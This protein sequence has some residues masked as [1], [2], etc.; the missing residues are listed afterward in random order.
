ME[1]SDACYTGDFRP[2]RETVADM[3]S[4]S[5]VFLAKTGLASQE[6]I[7]GFCIV[8][9]ISQPYIWSIA[10]DPK[11]QGRG[12]GGN[13]LREVIRTY[14]LSKQKEITLH[15]DCTNSAQKLYYD[16]GFRVV[17]VEE[18]YFEPNDGLMMVRKLP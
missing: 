14:T 15:V 2:P 17:S 16:Y 18:N 8:K 10:V 11:F 5:D 6:Q 7:I 9:N 1:I 12:V 13:I 3:I 4:V